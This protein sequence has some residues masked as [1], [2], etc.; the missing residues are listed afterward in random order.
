[1]I[2]GEQRGRPLGVHTSVQTAKVK[3][4]QSAYMAA[5]FGTFGAKSSIS[6]QEFGSQ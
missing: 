4:L 3:G 1:M 6:R 2:G 5:F